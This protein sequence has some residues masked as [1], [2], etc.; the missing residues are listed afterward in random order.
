MTESKLEASFVR[1]IGL[2]YSVEKEL[3]E[4]HAGPQLR[5]AIRTWKS[6]PILARLWRAMELVR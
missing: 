3:R 6:R 5:A 1:Q 4:R 2:L